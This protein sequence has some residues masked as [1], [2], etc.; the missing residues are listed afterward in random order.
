MGRGAS[1]GGQAGGEGQGKRKRMAQQDKG[2]EGEYKDT[3]KGADHVKRAGRGKSAGKSK[4]KD[5]GKGK[6][7]GKDKNQDKKRNRHNYML[8]SVGP[9]RQFFESM[10]RDLRCAI[11]VVQSMRCNLCGAI[12]CDLCGC[13]HVVL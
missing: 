5:T 6:S 10:W 8:A 13:T 12:L 4:D 11:S 9:K 3:G 2:G 1:R 7:A